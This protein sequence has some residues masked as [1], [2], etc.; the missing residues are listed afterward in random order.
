MKLSIN[1]LAKLVNFELPPISEL[2]SV[3]GSKLAEVEEVIDLSEKYKDIIIVKVVTCQKIEKSDHLNLCFIDDGMVV[4]DIK[5]NNDGFIQ[6]VCGAANVKAGLITAWIPPGS[7]IPNTFN[8]EPYKLLSKEILG[9]ISNGMLAS[10]KELDISSDHT[11]IIELTDQVTPGDKFA[12]KYNLNDRIIVIENKMFTHRPDCFGLLGIARELS[13][14]LGHT[15]ISPSW[16][17]Q[18]DEILEQQSNKSNLSIDNQI[19]DLVPVFRAVVIDNIVVKVSPL[20]L[21][22]E[23]MKTGIKS[24]SNVVDITNYIMLL[25]GQPVHAYDY[26]KLINQSSSTEVKLIVRKSYQDEEIKLLNGQNLKLDDD[27]IVIAT[28]AGIIGLG[29]VMGGLLSSIDESTTKI[30]LEIATFDMYSIRR[31]SMKYGIF[32][33]AVTRYTKGQS[34]FQVN[35]ILSYALKMILDTISGCYVVQ[36]GTYQSNKLIKNQVINLSIDDINGLL[37]SK[38]SIT[39]VVS[40]LTSVEFEVGVQEKSLEVLAPDWRTDIHLKE[41]IIEEIGRLY[42]YDLIEKKELLRTV[43]PVSK[44][45]NFEINN[46]IRSFMSARGANEL[47]NYSFVSEKLINNFSQDVEEAYMVVNARS[48]EFK[49]YRMNLTASLLDKVHSNVKTG[50]DQFTIYEIGRVHSKRFELNSNFDD[51]PDFS[52]RLAMIYVLSDKLSKNIVGSS[53]FWAKKYL[54][55]L[56]NLFNLMVSY[57]D[58]NEADAIY[59]TNIEAYQPGRAASIFVNDKC[60]GLIG[61]YNQAVKHFFKLPEFT[62]G[63]EIDTTIFTK[64]S[65]INCYKAISRYP[66]VYRDLCFEVASNVSFDKLLTTLRTILQENINQTMNYE[67]LPIDIFSKGLNHNKRVTVRLKVYDYKQTL[68]DNVVNV[69]VQKISAM[70]FEQIK[71]KLV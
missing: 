8:K 66:S 7:I 3:I 31:T 12:D 38:L 56:F 14:I 4:K 20:W 10:S 16:Y 52:R 25:T 2:T 24:I 69:L 33:D 67:I 50:Y 65:N 28:Q 30:V 43:T 71:A 44:Y 18:L 51:V 61:E 5:R 29:G 15:F 70:I 9:N 37:G 6:V 13:G 27:T 19:E 68:N 23:L 35:I 49:Y 57:Q 55:G 34:P 46:K 60:C 45:L 62:A 36:S 63:F 58:I 21:Q 54:D 48:P 17:K 11:G 59:E 64:N 39:N 1:L 53:Y 41:D 40:I 22:I 26:N 32:S 47:L 42:G